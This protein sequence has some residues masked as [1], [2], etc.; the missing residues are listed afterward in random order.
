MAT[1]HY[2][3][4]PAELVQAVGACEFEA[5]RKLRAFLRDLFIEDG[6]NQ[7]ER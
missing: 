2:A 1:C 5:S 7:V 4:C 6:L 3:T